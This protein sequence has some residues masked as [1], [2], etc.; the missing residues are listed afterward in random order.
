[1][2]SHSLTRTATSFAA[3]AA[4]L[5]SLAACAPDPAAPESPETPA[6]TDVCATP[7]GPAV[8]SITVTG[9]FGEEP[10]IDFEAGLTTDT[11]QR[12]I[13]IEGD[14][15]T[16]EEGQV[17]DIAIAIYKANSGEML[18]THGF[19]GKAMVPLFAGEGAPPMLL[20]TIGCVSTGSRVVAAIAASDAF[21]DKGIDL[22]DENGDPFTVDPGESLVIVMDVIRILDRA[23]GTD[24][25]VVSGMPAVS[26]DATGTPSITIPDTAPPTELQLVVLKK[27]DGDVVSEHSDVEV[28][29]HGVSWDTKE[30]FNSSWSRGKLAHFSLDEVIP[31]FTLAIAG[32]TLGSQ[33]LVVAPPAQAY[34]PASD[35]PSAHPLAGQTLVFVIDILLAVEHAH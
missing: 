6:A 24:Q 10:E 29:Y 14:G 13:L 34:G 21:G 31:G 19:G 23:W 28:H 18:E 30:V 35:D 8:E 20:K 7:A 5:V 32:Q 2:P 17:V 27:G 11:T 9:G 25:P 15:R 4:L 33:V 1:M 22:E 16:V 26:L 3:I 12:Q